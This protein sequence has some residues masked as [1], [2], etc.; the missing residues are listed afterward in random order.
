MED[1]ATHRSDA[2]NA[3]E[4]LLCVISKAVDELDLEFPYRTRVQS[5]GRV[6]PPTWQPSKSCSPHTTPVLSPKHM[7]RS[8]RNIPSFGLWKKSLRV[9]SLV[10]HPN[11]HCRTTARISST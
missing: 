9:T 1:S 2:E 3:D 11:K 10:V 5:V 6:V 4:E 8:L 7:Q